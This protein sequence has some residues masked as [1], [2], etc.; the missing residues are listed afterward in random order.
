VTCLNGGRD[1]GPRQDDPVATGGKGLLTSV[2]L[3]ASHWCTSG[4]LEAGFSA[5]V[6]RSSNFIDRRVGQPVG[7]VLPQPTFSSLTEL[8]YQPPGDSET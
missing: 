1:L 4:D 5:A 6:G 3:C 7:L 2:P 8:T